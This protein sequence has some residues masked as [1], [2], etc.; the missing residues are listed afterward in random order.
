MFLG[1]LG[2]H[3][4]EKN[5]LRI[6]RS[7][8]D[9]DLSA[10]EIFLSESELL[11]IKNS[12]G[13]IHKHYDFLCK[14]EYLSSIRIEGCKKRKKKTFVNWLWRSESASRFSYESIYP[15]GSNGK[16]IERAFATENKPH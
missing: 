6:K 8:V 3:F 13:I 16:T 7:V 11:K 5:C 4:A 12:R 14:P 10:S 15:I 2:H 1:S 9:Y